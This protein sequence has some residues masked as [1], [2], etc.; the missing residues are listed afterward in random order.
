MCCV[1]QSDETVFRLCLPFLSAHRCLISKLL[2]DFTHF[3]LVL[4]ISYSAD[5]LI[6]N[7]PANK[8]IK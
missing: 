1:F 5:L 8:T 2:I 3:M 4:S 6:K 7:T